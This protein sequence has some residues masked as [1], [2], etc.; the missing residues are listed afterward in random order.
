V[1]LEN[2]KI[3]ISKHN[4][5]DFD[6]KKIMQRIEDLNKNVEDY[7]IEAYYYESY[8]WYDDDRGDG[9]HIESDGGFSNEYY[10]CYNGAVSILEH[11]FYQEASDA[12]D[13]LDQTIEKF[14]SWNENNDGGAFYFETLIEE[15]WIEINLPNLQAFKG[16]SLLMARPKNI[17]DVWEKIF[18][19]LLEFK[20]HIVFNDI[21]HA[22]TEPIPDMNATLDSWVS[23]LYMQPAI[24]ASVYIKEAALMSG[25]IK[26]LEDYVNANGSNDPDSYMHLCE[27]YIEN[28]LDVHTKVIATAIKGLTNTDVHQINRAALANLLA[29]ISKDIDTDAYRYAITERFYSE[30]TFDNFIPIFKLNDPETINAVVSKMDK[31]S[32]PTKSRHSSYSSYSSYSNYD[33]YLVHFLNGDFDLVFDAFKS[34]RK[35]LGWST[36]LKGLMLPFFIG[37]LA[38]F[39]EDA[40]TINRMIENVLAHSYHD[41]DGAALFKLLSTN[42]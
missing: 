42:E 17:N 25:N 5:N 23:F 37:L 32:M 15:G 24:N 16:Y 7:S 22:G 39:S 10:R 21:L 20:G 28:R 34:D 1:L 12:F 3:I 11:G 9:W 6:V 31:T 41:V 14:D 33:Y 4:T 29:S 26:I 36:S 19:S 38:G 35:E 2:K 30:M 13:L 40:I 27:L 8:E 18:A